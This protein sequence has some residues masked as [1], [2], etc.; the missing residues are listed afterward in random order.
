MYSN[1]AWP[2]FVSYTFFVSKNR[3]QVYTIPNTQIQ[4]SLL[5][6][7][8]LTKTEISIYTKF[9]Q[10]NN[11]KNKNRGYNIFILIACSIINWRPFQFLRH[12][13]LMISNTIKWIKNIYS[14][15]KPEF[16]K[17]T[18]IF[19][20]MLFRIWSLTLGI[21]GRSVYNARNLKYLST[22]KLF[23]LLFLSLQKFVIGATYYKKVYNELAYQ[24][25]K[26][27][28]CI[29]FTSIACHFRLVR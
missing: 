26:N 28:T 13:T 14:I 8:S 6:R 1:Y 16:N 21:L 20:L 25:K 19:S 5:P 29:Y 3:W 18:S 9:I 7:D 23:T 12:A 17:N 22:W 2:D 15:S 10:L 11:C 4:F 27:V 24:N